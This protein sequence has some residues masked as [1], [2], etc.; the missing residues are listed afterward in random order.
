MNIRC[1]FSQ[2]KHCRVASWSI[3]TLPFDD[4]ISIITECSEGIIFNE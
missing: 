2:Y 1:M 4:N 3:L